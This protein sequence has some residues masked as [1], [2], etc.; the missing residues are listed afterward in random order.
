MI[1]EVNKPQVIVTKLSIPSEEE[2]DEVTPSEYWLS[3]STL[4]RT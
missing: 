1:Q 3:D 2:A 4:G